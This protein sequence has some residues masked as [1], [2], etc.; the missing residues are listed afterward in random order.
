LAAWTA[1]A[2]YTFH[3]Q[4]SAGRNRTR[5]G[6]MDIF[7]IPRPVY[8]WYQSELTSEP[9]VYIADSWREGLTRLRVFS[10]CDEVELLVNGVSLGRRTPDADPLKA[11][12][13]HPPFSFPVCWQPG[14]VVARGWTGGEVRATCAVRTPGAPAGIELAID[15]DGRELSADGADLVLAYAR[16]VDAHGTT[17]AGYDGRVTFSV[18]GPA[19]VV[20]GSEIGANPAECFDGIAPV[21]VRAGLEAGTITLRAQAGGLPPAEATVES[22]P[23]TA[24]A[25]LAAARPIYDLPRVRLDL[26]GAGQHVQYGWTPWTGADGAAATCD[27]PRLG[28]VTLRPASGGAL[29]WRGE[30]NVPGPLGFVAEDGVCALGELALE[31]AGLEAGLYHLRTYHHGPSS[32]TD[33]MDPLHGKS[34][35]ADVAKLPPATCLDVTV[36]DAQ[37]SGR[38][39]AAFAPQGAG[40]RVPR[41]GPTFAEVTFRANGTDPV[42]VR[43]AATNGQGSVWLN[44]LDLTGSIDRLT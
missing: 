22:V 6:M 42:R 36:N 8:Y 11:N 17:V 30:S 44:G 10:N 20:G 15:M 41:S 39:A 13:D 37:G 28:T 24:D 32:D 40:Q 18:D 2:Y 14:E 19:D 12:L 27:L 25:I 34:H 3:P 43:L 38:T 26:G 31:F 9:M 5:G 1:H 33:P 23:A 7:R 16:I 29:R 4:T 35:E 21:L